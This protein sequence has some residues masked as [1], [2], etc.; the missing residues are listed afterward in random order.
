MLSEKLTF[1]EPERLV[2][3]AFCPGFSYE[4]TEAGYPTEKKDRILSE[5]KGMLPASIL[6]GQTSRE[7]YLPQSEWNDYFTKEI[8]K[9]GKFRAETD[10]IPVYEKAD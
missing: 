3:S 7:I 4:E 2:P 10:L 6:V 1:G 9:C 5:R 8:V